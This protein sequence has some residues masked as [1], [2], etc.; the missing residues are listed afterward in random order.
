MNAF[1]VEV[2]QEI[3]I[4]IVSIIGVMQTV[5]QILPLKKNKSKWYA[6]VMLVVALLLGWLYQ[7]TKSWLHLAIAAW[8]IAQLTY[9]IILKAI[10]GTVD[11]FVN[12]KK[13][14]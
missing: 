12:G 2:T 1:S 11:R 14:E 10:I 4:L 13:E 8:S 3:I 6:V 9:D 5:K 7:N